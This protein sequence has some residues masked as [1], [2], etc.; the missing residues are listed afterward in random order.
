[1]P[2]NI[3]D[4]FL[5]AQTANASYADGLSA[6]DTDGALSNRLT[7]ELDQKGMTPAQAKHFGDNFIVVAQQQ[8][9]P[10]GFSAT[11]FQHKPSGDYYFAM[12]GT[13][14]PGDGALDNYNTCKRPK[15]VAC[16]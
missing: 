1:M 10:N 4:S 2:S 12:R 8:T 6:G 16:N 13:D 9:T 7:A 5:A 15:F 3:E 14:S 11:L